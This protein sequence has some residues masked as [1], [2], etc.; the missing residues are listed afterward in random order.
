MDLQQESFLLTRIFPDSAE[1]RS[2]VEYDAIL[3]SIS[4]SSGLNC[5]LC[6]ANRL[7]ELLERIRHHIQLISCGSSVA[8]L[9]LSFEREEGECE[10]KECE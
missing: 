7:L 6:F 3:S 4:I 5:C 2:V 1:L 9:V 8:K 10:R